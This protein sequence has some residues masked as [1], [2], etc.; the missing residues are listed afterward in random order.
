MDEEE[1]NREIERVKRYQGVSRIIA[2]LEQKDLSKINSN[3]MRELSSAYRLRNELGAEIG[4]VI[5]TFPKKTQERRADGR[6]YISLSNKEIQE[7]LR[8][9][10]E[11]IRQLE[12]DE[13]ASEEKRFQ[14]TLR[15]GR[16]I[17]GCD[18]WEAR[19]IASFYSWNPDS[20]ESVR[21]RELSKVCRDLNDEL[22]RI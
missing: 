16:N 22:S 12:R 21:I 14:A 4:S 10:Q 11:T 2:D 15:D 1:L 19:A 13:K 9:H 20:Y 7:R 8:S 17:T 6:P 3:E 18:C 5:P